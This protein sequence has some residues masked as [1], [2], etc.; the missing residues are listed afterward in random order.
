MSVGADTTNHG[1][2]RRGDSRIAPAG[3][4]TGGTYAYNLSTAERKISR[5]RSMSSSV[6]AVE[7]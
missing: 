5:V 2:G 7:T 6:W 3:G 1:Y 4:W